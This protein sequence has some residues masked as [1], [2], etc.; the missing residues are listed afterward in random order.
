M[1]VGFLMMDWPD[2]FLFLAIILGNAGLAAHF[3]REPWIAGF[4]YGFLAGAV[5]L[6]LWTI[7]VLLS[8]FVGEACSWIVLLSGLSLAAFQYGPG[9]ISWLESALH[10]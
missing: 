3:S 8:V 10:R 1:G 5:G 2:R 6:S 7:R 9:Y 4:G